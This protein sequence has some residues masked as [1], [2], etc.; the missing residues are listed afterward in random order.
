[1]KPTLIMVG[2]DKGGVGKT[3]VARVLMDFFA[4]NHIMT[5]AF[6]TEW[7]RG[8]LKRFYP[9]NCEVIN[10][11]DVADQMKVLDTLESAPEKVTIVDFKAGALGR[12]LDLFDKI[13]VFEAARADE[14]DLAMFHV[15]GPA[16]ASL[17]ELQEVSRYMDG[18]DYIVVRNFI[19]ETNF[20]EWDEETYRKYF[21][22]LNNAHEMEVPKLNEMAYEAVDLNGVTFTDFVNNRKANGEEADFSFTLRGYVRKW[23]SDLDEELNK[24]A[25]IQKIRVG[26]GHPGVAPVGAA[27]TPT[28]NDKQAAAE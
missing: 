16:V 24:L 5:R 20:F 3:T 15:V 28:N 21:A 9:N 22:N 2:A 6:D 18:V 4:R 25:L 14:F 7:P 1:M 26:A 10:I 11:E 17:N 19:N 13:G 12:T 8:T 23:L 27:G